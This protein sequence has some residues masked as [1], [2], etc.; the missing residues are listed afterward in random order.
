MAGF[1]PAIT[2]RLAKTPKF[3]TVQSEFGA[4]TLRS[5]SGQP[6]T[7]PKQAQAIG[8]SEAR[9]AIGRRMKRGR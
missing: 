9:G 5:S 7:D 1:N 2:R 3:R 6:V 8:F 4:G